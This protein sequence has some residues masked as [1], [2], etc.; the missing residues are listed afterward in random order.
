MVGVQQEGSGCYQ[1]APH[2]VDGQMTC[3]V[4]QPYKKNTPR[5]RMDATLIH[6]G[7]SG[8]QQKCMTR[9]DHSLRVCSSYASIR[10]IPGQYAVQ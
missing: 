2:G 6:M 10:T 5:A 9:R 1:G 3:L 8:C 4:A 7:G